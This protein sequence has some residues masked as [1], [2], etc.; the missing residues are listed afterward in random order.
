MDRLRTDY[1]HVGLYDVQEHRIWIARQAWDVVPIRISH[2]RMLQGGSFDTAVADKDR[3]LCFW[4]H[5][6]N[7]GQGYVHGYPIEWAEGHLLVRIDPNW[8]YAAGQLIPSTQTAKIEHN[9]DQQYHWGEAIFKAYVAMEPGYP[10]S[11]HMIGPR[12]TD[13]MF[14]VQR[15]EKNG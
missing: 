9:L 13:S 4:F 7:T 10:I 14:Y 2:A 8:N 3:F 15:W 1:A 12:A 11:L 6:P 5:T